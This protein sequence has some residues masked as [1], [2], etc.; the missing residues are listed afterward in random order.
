MQ[1][2]KKFFEKGFDESTLTKLEIFQQYLINWIP[3]FIKSKHNKSIYIFDFFAGPGYDSKNTAGSP[4]RILEQIQKIQSE[5]LN[6]KVILFF[7]EVN[8]RNYR[9]LKNT[10]ED[11]LNKNPQIK[12]MVE[13]NYL[14]KEFE[15]SFKELKQEIGKHPSL[16][17]LDQFGIKFSTYV[18]EFENFDKTDFLIFISSSYIKRFAN[19]PEFKKALNLTNDEIEKFKR[20]PYKL[21]HESVVQFLMT[22]LPYDAKLKLIPFS[23]KKGSNIYGLI[24][25]TK[26]I[27]GA[28]KF[29][30]VTW[31]INPDNGNANYDIYNDEEKKQPNLFPELKDKTTIQVFQEEL[32]SK[33]LSGEISTNKETYFFTIEKGFLP[34]HAKE[35]LVKLRKDGIV[36]FKSKAPLINYNAIKK[37]RIIKYE[38]N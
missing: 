2:S 30:H 38:K 1:K 9:Q 32:K 19:T 14:N 35:V 24:F 26:H 13:I 37:G 21:I 6:K 11:Y 33:I 36:K 18:S 3:V 25:G 12:K 8:K 20:T 7:N 28:D 29:L 5:N 23:I 4:I 34:N 31:K 22:K 15:N 27:L 16:V 17:F 10:C